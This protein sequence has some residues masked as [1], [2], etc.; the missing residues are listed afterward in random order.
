M[1]LRHVF[2]L[3]PLLLTPGV[4][5]AQ[6]GAPSDTAQVRATI[7]A[8]FAA[9]ERGDMIALDTLYAGEDL[10]VIEGTG[11]DRGWTDYRDDHLGPELEAFENFE[12]RPSEVEPRVVGDV[13][14]AIFRYTLRGDYG[15]RR[16][17]HV[18][19]GTA[20]LERRGNRWV[21]RHT[22]TSSRPR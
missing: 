14:W 13:A 2:L 16:L 1:R 15:D 8:L 18:G 19:R 6:A 22:H 20:I 21:V 4:A 3:L 10:T 12:Y 9:A 17:D 11:I 5:Q 7:E